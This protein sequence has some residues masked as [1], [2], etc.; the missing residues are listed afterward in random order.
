VRPEEY[1]IAFFLGIVKRRSGDDDAAIAAFERIPPDHPQYAEA[2]TQLAT[3][4]ERRSDYRAALREVEKASAGKPSRQLDL[5]AATLRAKGGDFDGAVAHL[6]GLLDEEPDDDELLYNLG[7]VYGEAK[8]ID[9]SLHYMQLALEKNP[10][11]ANALNYV[12]Y[13]WAERGMKLD[14]AEAMI[15]RALELRPDDGYILDS[16]GW[17]YYMRARP[18]V[19]AGRRREAQRFLERAVRELERADELTGGDPVVSEHLGDT[20]LLLEDRD[21]ALGYFE[22]A[23]RLEPRTGEQPDLLKKLEN[24]RRELE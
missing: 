7:V 11:N 23:V 22:E 19:E 2:R 10:D 18:L 14:E 16:L 1:E 20:Y 12:G 9:E 24:L 4:Y 15:T 21:T 13:T 3:I 17:V 5:Y 8:R 6:H